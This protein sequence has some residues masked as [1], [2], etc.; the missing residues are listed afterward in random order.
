MTR[1]TLSIFVLL[2]AVICTGCI[3]M[4]PKVIWSDNLAIQASSKDEKMH[5]DNMYTDGETSPLISERKDKKAVEEADKYTHATLS[6]IQ[7]QKVE[8]IVIK[9]DEGQLEF[10]EALYKDGEGNWKSLRNVRDNLK[11]TYRINMLGRPIMT[12]AIRLKI[13]RRWDSRRVG[14]Q[15]RR[16]RGETGAPQGTSRKIREIEVYHSIALE[17]EVPSTEE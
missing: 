17:P 4:G 13:P 8:K 15:K 9:S 2:F 14:G 5:D 11:T 3:L 6:W 1:F 7:T 10:F 12:T 16:A